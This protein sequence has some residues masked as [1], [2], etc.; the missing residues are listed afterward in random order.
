MRST[1]D[2][3]LVPGDSFPNVKHHER[4]AKGAFHMDRA[5]SYL[6]LHKGFRN[7]LLVSSFLI[8]SVALYLGMAI[9]FLVFKAD[10]NGLLLM[11]LSVLALVLDIVIAWI[12]SRSWRR[13]FG[14]I[15]VLV[16]AATIVGAILV[17]MSV[18][19]EHWIELVRELFRSAGAMRPTYMSFST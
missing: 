1:N 11:S 8:S 12:L 14:Q 17:S 15:F 6:E 7:A 18:W 16:S 9:H 4:P 5:Q 13:S 10:E 3:V 2:P 19:R